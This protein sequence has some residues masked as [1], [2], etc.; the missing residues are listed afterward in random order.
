MNWLRRW[1]IWIPFFLIAFVFVYYY[2]IV[3]IYIF[4]ALVISL[5]GYPVVRTLDKVKIGKIKIPHSINALVALLL[6]IGIVGGLL[7]FLIPTIIS[8]ARYMSDVDVYGILE[9]LK[10]PIDGFENQLREY[11]LLAPGETLEGIVSGYVSGFLDQID[12]REF[13]GSLFGL[14]GEISI[15]VFSI[16]FLAFFFLRDDKLFYKGLTAFAPK[17]AHGEIARILFYGKKMLSRY[18]IGLFFE[19]VLMMALI[20]FGMYIIGLPNAIF[21]G[22]VAGL[23]NIIPYLG[24]IIGGVVG[25]L[26]GLTT[27]PPELF[28]QDA[29]PLLLKMLMVFAA[30]NLIDNFVLQPLIYSKSVKAH[31]IEIFLVVIMVGISAGPFGMILAIPVYTLVRIVAMEFFGNWSLIKR[32]T[33]DLSKELKKNRE[34]NEP[35]GEE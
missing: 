18:F 3:L 5:M 31:P 32:I 35:A 22:V 17:E 15:S 10:G 6:V 21:I 16:I 34:N 1:Y 14:L 13:V 20:S 33:G 19:Q 24:P 23:F 8:Q 4:T 25:S 28:A 30:A 29:I 26:I 9:T 11:K 2:S 27:L 12:I 7:Y